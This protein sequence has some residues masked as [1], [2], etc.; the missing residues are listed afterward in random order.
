[1]QNEVNVSYFPSYEIVID[2]LRDYR[3][4]KTDRV[5]P[6]EEAVAYVWKRF[7]ETYFSAATIALNEEVVQ[8][9]SMKN[10]KVLFPKSK[11]SSKFLQSI[12]NQR[13]QLMNKGVI[14]AN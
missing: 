5:H 14:I 12:E 10:H 3:F 8:Y 13:L 9:H 6:T 1:M 7:S 11:A 4:Y 2:E